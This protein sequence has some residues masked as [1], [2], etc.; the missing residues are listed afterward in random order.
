MTGR[1]AATLLVICVLVTRIAA[2]QPVPPDMTPAEASAWSAITAGK[3][4]N[5]DAMCGKIDPERAEPPDPCRTIGH[6]FLETILTEAP[7]S[8]QIPR[9]GVH[10]QGAFIRGTV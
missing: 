6:G 4:A 7:W 3:A 5:F 8:G 10:I 9:Q 1:L 2:A